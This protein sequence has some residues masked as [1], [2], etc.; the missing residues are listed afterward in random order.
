M[1][2]DGGSRGNP[3]PSAL[4]VYVETLDKGYSLYIGEGTN[5]EAEYEAIAYA[6]KKLKSLL[7][8]DTAKQTRIRFRMDSQLAERQLNHAYKIKEDR[9][10]KKFI[11]IWNASIDFGDVLYEHVPREQNTRADA[12]VNRALDEADQQMSLL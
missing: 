11:A 5:N 3:G 2:T 10:I 12:L 6:L 7:G 8:A 4:G 1:Y 9:I